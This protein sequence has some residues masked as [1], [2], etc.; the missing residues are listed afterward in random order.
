V[1]WAQ[2]P[3][4]GTI[5]AFSALLGPGAYESTVLEPSGPRLQRVRQFLKPDYLEVGDRDKVNRVGD[6]KESHTSRLHL[7]TRHL[8]FE[9]L[10]EPVKGKFRRKFIQHQKST[11]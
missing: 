10:C 8:G 7:K 4:Y 2:R 1:S 6:L 3:S 11:L 5:D 9:Q